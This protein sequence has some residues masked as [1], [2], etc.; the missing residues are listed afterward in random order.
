MSTK[1]SRLPDFADEAVRRDYGPAGLSAFTKIMQIWKVPGI[2][3]RQLLGLAKGTKIDK[4]D[5]E[6]LSEEQLLRISYL[7]GIYKA[8]R[9][10]YSDGLAD[11]WTAG[12][13]FAT[14]TPYSRASL[15]WNTWPKAATSA[16]W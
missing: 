15:R 4:L 14:P 10:M 13:C 8:S 16:G 12:S 9:I 1:S 11:R 2:E 5:P 3:S 7:I 6:K